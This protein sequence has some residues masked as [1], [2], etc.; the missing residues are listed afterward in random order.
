MTLIT[1]HRR[2]KLRLRVSIRDSGSSRTKV[3]AASCAGS[4]GAT[5]PSSALRTP[6]VYP[7]HQNRAGYLR[8]VLWEEVGPGCR[9]GDAYDKYSLDCQEAE[10]TVRLC[11]D[12]HFP[13]NIQETEIN[14]RRTGRTVSHSWA[15]NNRAPEKVCS[16]RW[17]LAEAS[18]QF[19]PAVKSQS[20]THT[21]N[22]QLKTREIRIRKMLCRGCRCAWLPICALAFLP[23]SPSPRTFAPFLSQRLQCNNHTRWSWS[24]CRFN[25]PIVTFKIKQCDAF[26]PVSNRKETKNLPKV[27][28]LIR[29]YPKFSGLTSYEHFLTTYDALFS[30]T[31]K[32][33]CFFKGSSLAR[34]KL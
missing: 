12:R 27:F 11:A 20:E 31:S 16:G 3:S 29:K 7:P 22:W 30:P 18:G 4:S 33:S 14:K 25:F 19:S 1:Q 6:P 26:R 21:K 23:P 10:D 15:K 17:W 24:L 5:C 28:F 32:I 9:R 8:V 2:R 34:F 13:L